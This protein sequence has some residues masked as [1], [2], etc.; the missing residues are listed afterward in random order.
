[1][2]PTIPVRVVRDIWRCLTSNAA[3]C[4]MSRDPIDPT[5]IWV[6][7]SENDESQTVKGPSNRSGP[8]PNNQRRPDGLFHR[9]DTVRP[10]SPLSLWSL[11][12]WR[13]IDPICVIG[14]GIVDPCRQSFDGGVPHQLLDQGDITPDIGPGEIDLGRNAPCAILGPP[15]IRRLPGRPL[16]HRLRN[17]FDRTREQKV[18]APRELERRAGDERCLARF[19]RVAPQERNAVPPGR[20][21]RPA[22][23]SHT[24]N[25]IW[26]GVVVCRARTSSNSSTY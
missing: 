9:G 2:L 24:A 3:V 7:L 14:D 26:S 25:Q 21:L 8:H 22:K 16:T 13:R 11:V 19:V 10:M 15:E 4:A 18:G 1:V 6:T 5:R 12:H 17:G 20:I 23:P